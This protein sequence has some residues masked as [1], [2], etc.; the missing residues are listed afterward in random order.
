M[1]AMA[2]EGD[3]SSTAQGTAAAAGFS[4][5]PWQQIPKFVPGTTNL[6]DYTQ[7]LKFLKE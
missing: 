1:L 7:R 3:G 5:L 4:H 2:G 6:D